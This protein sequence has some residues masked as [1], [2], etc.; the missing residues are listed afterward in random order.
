MGA[1]FDH[2]ARVFGLTRV[3]RSIL[4]ALLRAMLESEAR[5]LTV[6]AL[7][8]A[9]AADLG[10]TTSAL[11]PSGRLT[12]CALVVVDGA[13]PM[14]TRRVAIHDELWPRLTGAPIAGVMR[15]AEQPP[16]SVAAL[17]LSATTA[18][19]ALAAGL[20]SGVFAC[21][22]AALTVAALPSWRRELAWHQAVP[23][24]ADAE[25]AEPAAL[26][27]LAELFA[28]PLV[29]TSA[30]PLGA[31]LLAA[32]RELHVLEVPR[33]SADDRIALWDKALAAHAIAPGAVDTAFLGRRFGFG[34]GRI[35]TAAA[36]HGG[37][38]APPT[39]SAAIALCRAIPEVH[40]GGL[41]TRLP[42]AA[43]TELAVATAVRAELALVETWA[44]GGVTGPGTGGLACLFH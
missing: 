30:R 15:P 4:E 1:L 3:E 37:G 8:E 18:A 14:L 9:A 33:P 21:D 43:W 39:T 24:I 36:S 11:H 28:G 38:R 29:L 31:R 10:A 2:A 7:A 40:V 42:P 20:G 17:G 12:G 16:M 32:G 44:R 25:R 34:P 41:A 35:I 22:G 23:V 5:S 27:A 26:A 19:A 6:A 13:G